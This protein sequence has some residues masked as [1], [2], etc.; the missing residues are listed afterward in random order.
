MGF[1]I[2]LLDEINCITIMLVSTILEA[3][4]AGLTGQSI[5][6]SSWT[7]QNWQSKKNHSPISSLSKNWPILLY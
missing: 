4:K 6:S 7:V 2:Y 3:D 5:A 1:T